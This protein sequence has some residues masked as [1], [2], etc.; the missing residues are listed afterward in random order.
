MC[1]SNHANVK[2]QKILTMTTK[3]YV[4][5][6][7]TDSVGVNKK[8][9][10]FD[11]FSGFATIQKQKSIESLHK[12]A[13]KLY[14]LNRI[15][16]ISSKSLD[17]FGRQLS[18]FNLFLELENNKKFFMES[19]FQG[20][21]VFDNGGP[22]VDL[23]HKSPIEAKR[24]ERLKNSGNLIRFEFQNKIFDL[25]PRTLFYDWLYA[26]IIN[27]DKK[28][29]RNIINYDGFTDIEFN[30][31]RSINCQAYS[32]ALVASLIKNNLLN[33][34]LISVDSFKKILE[35]EYKEQDGNS[36]IQGLFK[37]Q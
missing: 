20:S 23:Y 12:N 10:F 7:K 24:D 16:E 17:P 27:T 14:N 33:Q 8:E 30:P 9:V 3:R 35:K 18:A 21:K 25:K 13:N 29:L 36:A 1:F 11:W 6:P 31:Q 19:I 22:F 2:K 28:I 34:A 32:A 37:F 4:Y 26:S 5:T 15:L